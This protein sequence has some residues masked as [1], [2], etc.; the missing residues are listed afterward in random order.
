VVVTITPGV[1]DQAFSALGDVTLT[2]ALVAD[3]AGLR[4]SPTW[5]E[6]TPAAVRGRGIAQRR[7]PSDSL[8]LIERLGGGDRLALTD[9]FQRSR[10]GLRRMVELRMDARLLGRGVPF[11]FDDSGRA[12][13]QGPGGAQ[14]SR[15]H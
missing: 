7:Y 15:T 14:R 4:L 11:P 1:V 8:H 13:T 9:L 3:L 10:D 2:D 6:G 5:A 12:D